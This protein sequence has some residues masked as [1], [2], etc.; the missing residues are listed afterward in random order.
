MSIIMRTIRNTAVISIAVFVT[1]S[2]VSQRTAAPSLDRA[3]STAPNFLVIVADDLGYLDLGLFGSE[4]ATPN[5]DALARDGLLFTN[6]LVSPTC[7]PTRAMLLTG[8]DA[9]HAG[10]GTMAGEADERQRGAPGYEGNLAEH[11]TTIASLL[12]THGYHTNM[13]GK[14]HLGFDDHD[15]PHQRGFTRSFALIGGG[16]SHFDDAVTLVESDGPALYRKDGAPVALPEGFF[17]SDGY[18]DQLLK[19]MDEAIDED[20]PFFSYAAYTAPHWPLQASEDWIDRYAGVYDDGY[21]ALRERRFEAAKMHGIVAQDAVVP[22]RVPFAPA[23]TSLDSD[24]QRRSAREMEIYAAMVENLDHNIGRLVGFLRDRGVLEDTTI[25]FL[26]DN[27]PEGNDVGQIAGIGE[28]VP[29]RFDNS[30][31]NM[32][33]ADSYVWYGPAWAQAGAAPFRLFK[34]FP[35]EGGVR[36]P[37]IVAGGGFERRGRTETLATVMDI[38]PTL[39]DAAGA[40]PHSPMDGRSMRAFLQ[41]RADWLHDD[42]SVIAMELF[43]RRMARRGDWKAV[44][45]YPPYGPGQWELFDLASDPG[46][47]HDLADQRPLVA[48]AL[49][50]AWNKYARDVGVVLPAGDAGYGLREWK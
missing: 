29:R 48:G 24:M 5:I 22:A 10:L 31:P 18:T 35:T 39:L 9:H 34:A 46:E 32:G 42:D 38:A 11:V 2:C 6:F 16:A 30:L 33:R 44:W 19:F 23:W 45:L 26:A 12:R 3:H 21:D 17:S 28:W 36:V 37:A 27:G 1:M 14:W 8:M 25:I 47:Q 13:A 20:K 41:G 7:S 15:G 49:V 50:A 4:I 40:A 43:G